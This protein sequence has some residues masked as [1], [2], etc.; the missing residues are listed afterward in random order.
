MTDVALEKGTEEFMMFGEY[1]N[2]CKKYWNITD[3][4]EY[5]ESII[6]DATSF[7]EKYK[8]IPLAVKISVAFL[9]SQNIKSQSRR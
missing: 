1:F 8:S 9:E 2:L 6:A 7:S 5:W 4:D 3:T